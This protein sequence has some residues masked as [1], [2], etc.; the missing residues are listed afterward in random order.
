MQRT[1]GAGDSTQH[2]AVVVL[3]TWIVPNRLG[4]DL[5]LLVAGLALVSRH[6]RVAYCGSATVALVVSN[7]LALVVQR[8]Y[9]AVVAQIVSAADRAGVQIFLD[10]CEGAEPI[11]APVR[12]GVHGRRSARGGVFGTGLF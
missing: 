3:R 6:P 9:P 8:R 7:V 1:C 10:R 4:R 11:N 2:D 5:S 12:G